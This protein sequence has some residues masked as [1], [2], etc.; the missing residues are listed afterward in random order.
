MFQDASNNLQG[1]FKAAY[2]A[3][4]NTPNP[5][6]ASNSTFGAPSTSS[7]GTQSHPGALGSSSTSPVFGQS[8]FGQ[9]RPS[10]FGAQPTTS[11]FNASSGPGTGSNPS[12]G[13]GFA[14][15]ASKPSVFGTNPSPTSSFAGGTQTSVFGR[16]SAFGTP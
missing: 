9:S 3:S 15:F 6:T 4:P 13:S 11:A 16:P 8:S 5:P 10:G 14:A 2:N 12:G 7:F 1:A